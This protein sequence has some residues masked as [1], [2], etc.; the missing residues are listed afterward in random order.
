AKQRALQADNER[1]A[2][3]LD[4]AQDYGRIGVWER[5]VRTLQGRWDSHVWRFWG[6]EPREGALPFDAALAGVVPQDREALGALFRRSVQRCGTYS[7]RF[8]LVAADG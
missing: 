1:L 2:E 7:M 5:D 8:R 4:M 6:L 3:L